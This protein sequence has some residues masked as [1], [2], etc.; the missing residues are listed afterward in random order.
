MYA[1]AQCPAKEKEDFADKI[2]KV[3]KKY[4]EFPGLLAKPGSNK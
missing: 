2:F 3:K 4:D 1:S